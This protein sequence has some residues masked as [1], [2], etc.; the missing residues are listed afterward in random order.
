MFSGI[1]ANVRR[2][3]D[4]SRIVFLEMHPRERTEE[5]RRHIITALEKFGGDF[6]ASLLRK[7]FD[8]L[9]GGA[10]DRALSAL[11][12]AIRVSGGDERKAD[13][14]AHL[15]AANHVLVCNRDITTV[16]AQEQAAKIASLDEGE[17]SDEEECLSH[18][19]GHRVNVEY[20]Y[21]RTLGEWIGYL[22]ELVHTGPTEDRVLAELERHGV[23][24]EGRSVKIANSTTG[25]RT[26]YKGT[27]WSAGSHWR[28]IR[29]LPKAEPGGNA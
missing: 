4:R 10:F 19:M 23:K 18:L 27:R 26:A 13:V 28:I 25:I 5:Q 3:A 16:E 11:R 7:M 21:L 8:A 17:S 24:V 12:I 22:Q 6:G 15:L 9:Y 1:I 14:F 2:E 29:R 20:G